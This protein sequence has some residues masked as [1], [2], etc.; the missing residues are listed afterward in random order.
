MAERS[1]DDFYRGTIARLIHRDMVRHGGLIRRDDL[2][3]VQPPIERKPVACWFEGKR[4]MTFP[5]PGAG[6]TLIEMLNI[7]AGLHKETRNLDRPQG[8]L[9]LSRIMQQAYRDRRDRP[10]DPSFY[11]QVSDRRMLSSDYAGKVARRLRSG[12]ETTHLSVMDKFGNA[13][14][15]TQSIERVYGSCC[16]CPDLGFLYNNYLLAFE[17]EDISHPYFLRPNAVPWASVA[18]TIIFKDRRPWL[19]IGSPGGD[20][21]TPTIFQVLLRLRGQSPY[22]AVDA[23]RLYCSLENKVYLEASRMRD[24]IPVTLSAQGYDVEQRG[25]YSFYLGCVQLVMRENDTFVGVADPRRD[26][27]ARGPSA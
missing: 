3:Q 17:H 13:V 24:D 23:P 2:A 8:A 20:R 11:A 16:A 10:Y 21:I 18:P 15:L 19:V 4:L 12:G 14:G 26:G 27:E 7:A 9:M 25:P 1:V 22:A 6:R 5:P